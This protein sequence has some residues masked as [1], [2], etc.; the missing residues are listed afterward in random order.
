MLHHL[1]GVAEQRRALDELAR[2]VRPGGLVFVHEI[3]TVNPL[4]RL[5]MSY[6]FPLLRRIDLGT[7][8]WLDPRRPPCS[9]HLA[10][11]EVRCYTF[12]P[13]FMPRWLF[14]R[15]AGVEA[16]LERSPLA[17][18]GAHFTA[19]YAR[20]PDYLLPAAEM[21]AASTRELVAAG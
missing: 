8:R 12:W 4:Y 21:N 17:G 1:D 3:S 16:W 6:V 14:D 2:T 13:D 9:A 10:L 7:E 19:V 20:R 18:Y 11:Q 5:Y 15:L